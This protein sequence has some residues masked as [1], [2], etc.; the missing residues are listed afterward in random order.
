MGK[1]AMEM[2][3]SVPTVVMSMAFCSSTKEKL[4]TADSRGVAIEEAKG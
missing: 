3:E 4:E 2:A 1:T